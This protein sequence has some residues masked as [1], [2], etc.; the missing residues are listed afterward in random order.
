LTN[1]TNKQIDCLQ[2]NLETAGSDRGII[3]Y[4]KVLSMC[5][6]TTIVVAQLA[7]FF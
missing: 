4:E 5:V 2:C 1:K 6:V 3:L 7:P